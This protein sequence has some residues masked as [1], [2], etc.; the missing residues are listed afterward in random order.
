MVASLNVSPL[1]YAS[2]ASHQPRFAEPW[3]TTLDT[4][5]PLLSTMLDAIRNLLWL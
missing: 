3:K 2:F 4:V 5:E 1:L